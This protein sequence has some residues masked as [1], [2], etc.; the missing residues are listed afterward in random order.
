MLFAIT[1][2]WQNDIFTA[3][4]RAWSEAKK[5]RQMHNTYKLQQKIWFTQALN[6][7]P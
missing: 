4:K 6:M 5:R 2:P 1:A 7:L 3:Y